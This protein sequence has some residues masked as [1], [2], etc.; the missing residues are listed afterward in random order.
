MSHAQGVTGRALKAHKE[1]L[2]KKARIATGATRNGRKPSIPEH[3]TRSVV[4]QLKETSIKQFR[5][6]AYDSNE[7]FFCSVQR[8]V[9]QLTEVPS[10]CL[11][12]G[13]QGRW[14]CSSAPLQWKRFLIR[15]MNE[16]KDKSPYR[17]IDY[18]LLVAPETDNTRYGKSIKWAGS[19]LRYMYERGG[20]SSLHFSANFND[21]VVN[22]PGP[23]ISATV[24]QPDAFFT[25]VSNYLQS[26]NKKEEDDSESEE[27]LDL[28]GMQVDSDPVFE[29]AVIEE[30]PQ[31]A[32][33]PRT[34]F[35]F[36]DFEPEEDFQPMS[37]PASGVQQAILI[38]IPIVE[39]PEPPPVRR[40]PTDEVFERYQRLYLEA[41]KDGVN[42]LYYLA[43]SKK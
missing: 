33:M 32:E 4:S 8:H 24:D 39:I 26:Q 34:D 29:N 20:I 3:I 21:F 11:L 27:S 5:N 43:A 6:C 18:A 13:Y 37:E 7:S 35:G 36:F 22:K 42:Y 38:D 17:K 2:N 9:E 28:S 30:V 10:M 31:E 23:G 41:A 12:L 40:A 15:V 1:A 16:M 14:T 19:I 25:A